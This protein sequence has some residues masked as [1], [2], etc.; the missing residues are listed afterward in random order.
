MDAEQLAETMLMRDRPDSGDDRRI[1]LECIG[2]K[3][4]EGAT[5]ARCTRTR[6]VAAMTAQAIGPTIL[7]RCDSFALRGA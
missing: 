7:Q 3:K 4:P 2:W 1:C 5:A 6:G